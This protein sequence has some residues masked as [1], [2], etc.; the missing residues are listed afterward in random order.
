MI[1][2]DTTIRVS[3]NSHGGVVLYYPTFR[4]WN[5]LDGGWRFTRYNDFMVDSVAF[6]TILDAFTAASGH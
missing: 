5:T 3:I 2:T 6:T 1:L 4:I